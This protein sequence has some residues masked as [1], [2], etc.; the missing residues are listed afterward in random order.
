MQ[1]HQ[2][3]KF[4]RFSSSQCC[5]TPESGAAKTSSYAR[6]G[7]RVSEAA[8]ERAGSCYTRQLYVSKSSVTGRSPKQIAPLLRH[9]RRNAS[10]IQCS[11]PEQRVQQ[12]QRRTRESLF[13]AQTKTCLQ[14][15]I[16]RGEDQD[17]GTKTSA[18]S[19]CTPVQASAQ[20]LPATAKKF[21]YVSQDFTKGTLLQ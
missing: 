15:Q 6:M 16:P 10:A 13:P 19:P 1:Q 3:M 12:A 21:Q 4:Q 18:T 2:H 14:H 9:S 11:C 5:P 8:M 20:L 7:S 17:G